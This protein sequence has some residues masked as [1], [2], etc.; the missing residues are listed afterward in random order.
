MRNFLRINHFMLNKDLNLFIYLKIWYRKTLYLQFIRFIFCGV[1]ISSSISVKSKLLNNNVPNWKPLN[2]IS[3]TILY[4]QSLYIS[5]TTN[6][7]YIPVQEDLFVDSEH[8]CTRM[9]NS[10]VI[11]VDGTRT[12]VLFAREIV[13]C[14]FLWL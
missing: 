4:F 12:R 14:T 9:T 10:C 6:S 1:D 13:Q 5:N 2:E 3:S 11:W 7:M 8:H